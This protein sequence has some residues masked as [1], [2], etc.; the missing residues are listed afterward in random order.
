MAVKDSADD[1]AG[2]T[3][4]LLSDRYSLG[5]AWRLEAATQLDAL[6]KERDVLQARVKELEGTVLAKENASL[7]TWID[8]HRGDVMSLSNEVDHFRSELEAA[9]S[10]ATRLHQERDEAYELIKNSLANDLQR[11]A[12]GPE[13]EKKE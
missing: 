11:L 6:L 1:I 7:R 2:L 12:S 9:E 3:R 8:L 10:R 5:R 13:K 4:A